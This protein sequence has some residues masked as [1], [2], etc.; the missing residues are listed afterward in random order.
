MSYG[1]EKFDPAEHRAANAA[2][3]ISSCGF[4]VLAYALLRE[5]HLSA[6]KQFC[7]FHSP[8]Y[9]SIILKHS[10]NITAKTLHEH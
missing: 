5:Y 8:F 6:N 10:M 7:L 3:T 2:A 1:K 9:L 4:A